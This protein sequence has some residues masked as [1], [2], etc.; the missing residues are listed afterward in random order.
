MGEHGAFVGNPVGAAVSDFYGVPVCEGV[1]LTVGVPGTAVG[2]MAV[3]SVGFSQLAKSLFVS[4][5]PA[6]IVPS[7]SFASQLLYCRRIDSKIT[8]FLG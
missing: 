3:D 4:C 1:G 2:D 5:S 6:D 7:L 8:K